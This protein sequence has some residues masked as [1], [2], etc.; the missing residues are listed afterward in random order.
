[1]DLQQLL[2]ALEEF[3]YEIA[4]WPIMVPRTLLRFGFRA[5]RTDAYVRAE[6]DKRDEE[7]YLEY[8]SPILLWLLVGFTPCFVTVLLYAGHAH[9]P[10]LDVVLKESIEARLAALLI[11]SIW[12]PVTFAVGILARSKTPITRETLRYPLYTQCMFLAPFYLIGLATVLFIMAD[13]SHD[14]QTHPHSA[15]AIAIQCIT[16][17]IAFL[18][19][20][21]EANLL[22]LHASLSWGRAITALIVTWLVGTLL[23]CV[24]LGMGILVLAAFMEHGK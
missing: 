12:P 24:M 15:P 5:L 18:A 4:L 17:P 1:M 9:N 16:T 6:L 22:R 10:V 14:P 8:T 13:P 3:I 7:R 23:E 19:L 11:V 20:I 2:R 21:G